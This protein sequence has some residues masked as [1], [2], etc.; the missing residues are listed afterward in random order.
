[1]S[2]SHSLEWL[3]LC[4]FRSRLAWAGQRAHFNE[5]SRV[6][7]P[8]RLPQSNSVPHSVGDF[9]LQRPTRIF[10]KLLTQTFIVV[11][12]QRGESVVLW[13]VVRSRPSTAHAAPPT[14]KTREHTADTATPQHEYTQRLLED[15]STPHTPTHFHAT[16]RHDTHPA[17]R[18]R[19]SR[20]CRAHALVT[21]GNLTH[22]RRRCLSTRRSA[23]AWAAVLRLHVPH[24]SALPFT[25]MSLPTTS[26]FP[27]NEM[28]VKSWLRG[29]ARFIWHC[30]LRWS[31]EEVAYDCARVRRLC[32]G[33]RPG[34]LSSWPL[35]ATPKVAR[36]TPIAFERV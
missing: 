21:L 7:R 31:G 20:T 27:Q 1:M 24:C 29:V 25:R 23:E 14:R 2:F 19:H 6:C 17:L 13:A 30:L 35:A 5:S 34:G 32:S 16:P 9:V 8:E 15:T 3:A 33:P 28:A 22:V 10:H 36:S 4:C 11:S 26:P 18:Q 12:Q